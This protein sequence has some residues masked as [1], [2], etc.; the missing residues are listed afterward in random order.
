MNN[1]IKIL[2]DAKI[3]FL[4]NANYSL[5]TQKAESL[6]FILDSILKYCKEEYPDTVQSVSVNQV[7]IECLSISNEIKSHDLLLQ[8][9][10]KEI[11]SMKKMSGYNKKILDKLKFNSE[12][13]C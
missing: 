11:L 8:G 4:M 9:K 6:E 3:A 5:G 7:F 1:R 12:E 2:D 10:I 13:F